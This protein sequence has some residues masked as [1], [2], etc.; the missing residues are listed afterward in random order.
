[1]QNTLKILILSSLALVA[2]SLPSIAEPQAPQTSTIDL[3]VNTVVETLEV[4]EAPRQPL[5]VQEDVDR[6]Q[7][8]AKTPERPRGESRTNRD[9]DS[10]RVEKPLLEVHGF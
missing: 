3:P 6:D 8:Q 4:K 9:Q 1:M 2:L 5:I 10:R 7:Q